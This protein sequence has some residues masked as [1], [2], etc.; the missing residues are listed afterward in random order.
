MNESRIKKIR[1]IARKIILATPNLTIKQRTRA[2]NNSIKRMKNTPIHKW[3]LANIPKKPTL[4]FKKIHL[5]ES[6]AKFQERRKAS[7]KRRR[8]GEKINVYS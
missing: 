3:V 1:K 4:I 6:W 7:N 2:Y 8:K 5:K